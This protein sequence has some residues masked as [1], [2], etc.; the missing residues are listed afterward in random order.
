MS[1]KINKNPF[2]IFGVIGRKK[3]LFFSI[4]YYII[5][6]LL[7]TVCCFDVIQACAKLH[8]SAAEVIFTHKV[9]MT[10]AIIYIITSCI[11]IYLYIVLYKKRFTDIFADSPR[12]KISV[13]CWTI[14]L[15][16][17]TIKYFY[18]PLNIFD[19]LFLIGVFLWCS[20][21]KGAITNKITQAPE[22]LKE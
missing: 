4:L 14:V 3:F 15:T 2:L 19:C 13:I 7:I 9:S 16:I 1:Y 11:S 8:L 22:E 20:C 21:N 10:P 17:Y 5:S 12:C 6:I 18:L